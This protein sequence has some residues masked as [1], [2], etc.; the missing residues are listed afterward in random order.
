MGTPVG[1]DLEVPNHMKKVA[2]TVPLEENSHA[3]ALVRKHLDGYPMAL[4]M[5]LQ[6][7]GICHSVSGLT[8]VTNAKIRSRV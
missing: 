1:S 2:H 4:Q 7:V 6:R 5:P 3:K 8:W